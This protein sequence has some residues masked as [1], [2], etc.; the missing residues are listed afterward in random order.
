MWTP[1]S[2]IIHKPSLNFCHKVVSLHVS[3]MSLSAVAL[4]FKL[5]DPNNPP[6][7]KVRSINTVL[8]KVRV[9]DLHRTMTSTPSNTFGMSWN[10]EC[11]PDFL[12]WHDL[13]T[14]LMCLW[15]KGQKLHRYDPKSSE[16]SS[17]KSGGGHHSK[18]RRTLCVCSWFKLPPKL[19]NS[20]MWLV[21]MFNQIKNNMT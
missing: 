16:V 7:C 9:K 18:E 2:R 4:R 15:L 19:W 5:K 11:A 8:A 17:Q 12:T 20:P 14:L 1:G 21:S 10:T 3:R 6:V 13:P